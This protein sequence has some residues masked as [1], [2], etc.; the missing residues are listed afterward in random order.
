MLKKRQDKLGFRHEQRDAEEKCNHAQTRETVW[1]TF[2]ILSDTPKKRSSAPEDVLKVLQHILDN[3]Q[4]VCI[5]VPTGLTSQTL[6]PLAAVLLEYLVAYVPTSPEQTSFLSNE[7]LDVYECLLIVDELGNSKQPLLKFSSPA[8]L[9]ID[10]LAP[11]KVIET[12]ASLFTNRLRQEKCDGWTIRVD[13]SVQCLDRV[14][15]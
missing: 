8:C 15:L 9:A 3:L 14:A 13:H 5:S 10:E 6:V 7:A 12:L 4:D 1:P 2:I 11:E